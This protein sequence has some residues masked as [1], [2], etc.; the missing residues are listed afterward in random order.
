MIELKSITLR[1]V[2]SF[3]SA[4][5]PIT[6]NSG[7]VLISGWNKDSITAVDQ[8]NGAGKTLLF[9]SIGNCRY[10][11][12]PSSTLKNTKKDMLGS[13][14]SEIELAF[15]DE[16]NQKVRFIQ[17]P[18]KWLIHIDEEDQKVHRVANQ[19]QKMEELWPITEDEFYAYTYI[20]SMAGQRL[21]FQVQ[22][23]TERLKFITNIFQLEDYDLLKGY[24]TRMLGTIKDEQTKFSVI[25]SKFLSINTQL[26]KL[27]WDEHSVAEAKAGKRKFKELK[28]ER[29]ILSSKVMKS[30]AR[31]ALLALYAKMLKRKKKASKGCKGDPDEQIGK[32]RNRLTIVREFDQYNKELDTYKSNTSRLKKKRDALVLEVE[33]DLPLSEITSEY[34]KLKDSL[35]DVNGDITE[36]AQIA[37]QVTQVKNRLVRVTDDL[38][39][40]GFPAVDD[41]DLETDIDDDISICRTTLKLKKL[42]DKN[43]GSSCPTCHQEVDVADI[44]ASVKKA[45]KRLAKLEALS[46]ARELVERHIELVAA[47]EKLGKVPN[48]TKLEKKAKKFKSRIDELKVMGRRRERIEELD[49]QLDDISKPDKPKKK[50]KDG[51][52]VSS[53]KDA[54]ELY[55]EYEKADDALSSFLKDHDNLGDVKN[56]AAEIESIEGR[57]SEL[58]SKLKKMD[59]RYQKLMDKNSSRDLKLG[60]FRVLSKQKLEFEGDMEAAKPLL[61]KR[62]L[63]KALE[64]TYGAKGLKVDAA[65]QILGLLEANLNRYAPLIFAE[66]F[67]FNVYADDHGIHCEVNRNNGHPATDVRLLSGAESDCFKLLFSVALLLMVPPERRTNFV[68]LDEPDSHMDPRTSSLFIERFLPF[69][70]EV[71]P[72]TFLITQSDHGLFSNCD[73]WTVVKQ[74]GVSEL[75]RKKV[76][77]G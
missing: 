17:K 15:L 49:E 32:L 22:K 18:S 51:E 71:V 2:V 31:L 44:A 21:H 61:E 14:K 37:K 25:E 74:D 46:D 65:N 69:L 66:P 64:H 12:A 53:I 54:I 34:A 72:H 6:K 11:S 42:L 30:R 40:L 58:E 76:D 67:D 23:P 8:N 24:F 55:R 28:E 52:T 38:S 4:K 73:S 1:N 50:P 16:Q 39:E 60:E 47:L 10:G 27:G 3:N 62:D 57:A 36:S 59:K 35:S 43:T 20:T 45:G 33:D 5:V 77:R 29:D 13:T 41:V 9:S 7:L 75:K 68:V 48:V 26:E 63:Y 70:R 56:P 19:Q